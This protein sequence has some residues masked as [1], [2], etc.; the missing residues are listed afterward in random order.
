MNKLCRQSPMKFFRVINRQ[1]A[2]VTWVPA[3]NLKHARDKWAVAISK[4]LSETLI[5]SEQTKVVQKEA[6]KILDQNW[7]VDNGKKNIKRRRSA[8]TKPWRYYT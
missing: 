5:L 4:V 8:P 7:I 2:W 1:T 3:K 6:L